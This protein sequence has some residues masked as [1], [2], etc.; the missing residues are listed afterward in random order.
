MAEIRWNVG[1]RSTRRKTP[2]RHGS[3]PDMRHM[4]RRNLK[5]GA[6]MIEF[7]LAQDQAQATSPGHHL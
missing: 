7:S 4:L 2:A 6:Q 5:Q 1:L 3:Y